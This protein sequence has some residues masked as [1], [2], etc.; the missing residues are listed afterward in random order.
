M[1]KC[2]VMRL[3]DVVEL[4][5]LSRATIYRRM[6]EDESFPQAF[7]VGRVTRAWNRSEVEGWLSERMTNNASQ[8]RSKLPKPSH[9]SEGPIEGTK[10]TGA[11]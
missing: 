11:A 4:L 6:K 10:K 7:M 3:K 1:S 2:P 8:T 5:N 9:K